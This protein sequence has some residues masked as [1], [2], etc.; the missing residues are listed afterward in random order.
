MT[1]L[2]TLIHREIAAP[3]GLKHETLRTCVRV[4]RRLQMEYIGLA[5]LIGGR[6]WRWGAAEAI[7]AHVH[8]AI[9]ASHQSITQ[10]RRRQAPVT[11]E[12]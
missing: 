8:V 12:K 2:G 4:T 3:T 10:C 7:V 5:H 1:L 9:I 11:P 6:R